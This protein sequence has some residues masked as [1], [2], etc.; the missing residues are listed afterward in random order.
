MDTR[1][2]LALSDSTF[3]VAMTLLIF[4]VRFK[5]AGPRGVAAD[6]W[7]HQWPHYVGY[8]VSFAVVGMLWLNHHSIFRCAARTDHAQMVL[9]LA[10]LG[11][12]VFIPFP[13][14]VVAAYL[15]GSSGQQ[16][17][18]ATFYGLTLALATLMLAAVWH[19]AAR[20]RQLLEP[21]VPT[22]KIDRLTRRLYLT[23]QLFVVA[24][25]IGLV[26]VRVGL[27]LFL[28]IACGY[29]L[30]TGTRVTPSHPSE[31]PGRSSPL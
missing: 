22:E 25:G 11:V 10:F 28:L 5:S 24:T 9:N 20:H 26:D 18:V 1:R 2:T 16:V 19:R 6:L 8:V 3:A 30:H 15:S 12:V 29:V 31:E 27:V 21:W 13:T 17:Y 4:D 7:F 23:P 14:Q